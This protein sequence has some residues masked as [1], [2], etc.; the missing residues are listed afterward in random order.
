MIEIE[1][2]YSRRN[3]ASSRALQVWWGNIVHYTASSASKS[4]ATS[5]GNSLWRAGKDK[6]EGERFIER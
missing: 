6:K 1:M 2:A 4:S 3:V 5:I